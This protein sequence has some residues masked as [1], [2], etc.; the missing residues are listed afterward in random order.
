M[1][2]IV[3]AHSCRNMDMS[4]YHLD[5]SVEDGNTEMTFNGVTWMMKMKLTLQSPLGWLD[6]VA[7]AMGV[8][9]D[10]WVKDMLTGG[11]ASLCHRV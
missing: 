4:L 3:R 10:F 2:G 6:C 11:K 5:I 7:F 1:K 9:G 8:Q